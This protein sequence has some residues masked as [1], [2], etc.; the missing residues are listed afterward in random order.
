MV[1]KS[2]P[3]NQY[4][5]MKKNHLPASFVVFLLLL[6]GT[7]VY[8]EKLYSIAPTNLPHVTRA[9]KTPGFWVSRHP[10]ADKI[11]LAK[12]E[13][14]NFN[15]RTTNDLKLIKDLTQFPMTFSGQTLRASLQETWG[16]L[17]KKNL[18]IGNARP[19]SSYFDPIL[20]N[21]NLEAITVTMP[22]QF[23]FIVRFADQRF[24]PT[25]DGLSVKP[26]DIDFD[27]L[28]NSDMD[29]GTPVAILH[30]SLD[31]EWLYVESDIA[32]GWVE[33][34][35][36]A[37]CELSDLKKFVHANSFAVVIAPKADIFLKSE[38]NEH[39]DYVRMGMRFPIISRAE[40]KV[41][42]MVPTREAGGMLN[43]KTGYIDK[44]SIHEG[45]LPYMPRII[46]EQAFKMLNSPYGWGGVNGEQDCSRFLQEVFATVGIS[47]PRDSVNQAKVG[48]LLASFDVQVQDD[49]RLEK[50]KDA[51]GGITLLPM[52]GHIMLFLGLVDDRPFAIHATWAY[53]DRVMNEDVALVINRVVVSDLSLGENSTRGSLLRRLSSIVLVSQ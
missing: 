52:K 35:K 44:N 2:I 8:G 39:Y 43:F 53:R 29:C 15:A 1:L 9:M 6:N 33:S 42:V 37:L 13:I 10:D 38:T 41:G 30:K 47:L 17:S 14:K 45:Y 23:G 20:D 40:S 12:K 24:L 5:Q 19:E 46:I 50:F 7:S 36:V 16:E 48:R 3:N 27:E 28:Q 32:A 25:K 51:V 31:G 49:Q 21:M 26:D 18:Y 22:V 4:P 34:S 11:I